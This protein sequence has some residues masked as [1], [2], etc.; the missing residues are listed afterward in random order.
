MTCTNATVHSIKWGSIASV[1]FAL[2][3]ALTEVEFKIQAFHSM[4]AE[5]H[6]WWVA[7]VDWYIWSRKSRKKNSVEKNWRFW[8]VAVILNG[9]FCLQ[10]VFKMSQRQCRQAEGARV[11]HVWE[12]F[13]RRKVMYRGKTFG[14]KS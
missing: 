9:R 8:G 6:L 12:Y 4:Y 7:Y 2:I 11:V 13:A 5:H 14:Q 10:M 3:Q 1:E